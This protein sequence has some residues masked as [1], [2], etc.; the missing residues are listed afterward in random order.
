MRPRRAN[1]DDVTE[2][3]RAR[4]ERGLQEL[5]EGVGQGAP[6]SYEEITRVRRDLRTAAEAYLDHL[7]AELEQ[8]ISDFGPERI[9]AFVAEPILASGGVL[10][11]FPEG[12]SHNEPQ[13]QP[14]KTGA[15][16]MWSCSPAPS[17]QRRWIRAERWVDPRRAVR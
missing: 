12:Q 8:A 7:V 14:L 10:A 5:D 4:Y 6:A 17:C 3:A 1:P 9:A 13:L 11:L 15:A 16:R 2:A